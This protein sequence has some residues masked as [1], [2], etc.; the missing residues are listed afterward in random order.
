LPDLASV[1][2]SA[3]LIWGDA[4]RSHCRSR[5]H[6]LRELLPNAECLTFEACGHFPELEAPQRFAEVLSSL[7]RPTL[8]EHDEIEY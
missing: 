3:R 2:Q 4:D 7:Q 6:S 5:V 8:G 1:P